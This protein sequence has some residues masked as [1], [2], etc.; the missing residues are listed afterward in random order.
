MPCIGGTLV[1]GPAA[2][3]RL[4]EPQRAT[5]HC[6]VAV[7]QALA[8][9]RLTLDEAYVFEYGLAL[10]KTAAAQVIR[11]AWPMPTG[12]SPSPILQPTTPCSSAR[13]SEMA[14]D[15]PNEYL[16]R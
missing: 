9:P 14:S 1:P 8:K 4:L 15:L 12:S 6:T 11:F 3:L 2:L 13:R 16:H 5:Q 7:V 10:L